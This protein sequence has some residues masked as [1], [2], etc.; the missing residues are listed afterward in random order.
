MEVMQ[1]F[2]TEVE[3][4][5]EVLHHFKEGVEEVVEEALLLRRRSANIP[6]VAANSG[7]NATVFP[8]AEEV[9]AVDLL[10]TTPKM[11]VASVSVDGD[12]KE[13][14]KTSEEIVYFDKN[15]GSGPEWS[16][17]NVKVEELGAKL[18]DVAINQVL[19]AVIHNKE[20]KLPTSTNPQLQEETDERVEVDDVLEETSDEEEIE[21]E[22][23]RAVERIHTHDDYSMYCPNC[24]SRITKVVL[25]RK[26]RQRRVQT[27]KETQRDDLFGCL[28][29]FSVFIPS[30]GNRLNPFRIFGAGKGPES[31]PLLQQEQQT[32]DVSMPTSVTAQDKGKGFDLFWIFG[33]RRP[34]EKLSGDLDSSSPKVTNE[35]RDQANDQGDGV[36]TFIPNAIPPVGM[37]ESKVATIGDG[38]MTFIPNAIPPVGMTESNVAT[39]G[40]GVKT[41]IPNALPAQG[42]V[43]NGNIVPIGIIDKTEIFVKKPKSEI[44]GDDVRIQVGDTPPVAPPI[45]PIT[46]VFLTDVRI[47]ETVIQSPSSRSLEIVKSIVYGGMMESIA[48]L[49]VVSSA[50]ASDATTLN[51]VALG[52]ANLVGGLVVLAHNLRDLRYGESSE[53]N[54]SRYKEQLGRKEHFFFHATLAV[55]S[56]LV[57]GLIPPVIYGF[58]FRESDDRDYKILAVAA[59]SLLCI[60]ILAIAKAYTRGEH[61]FVAYFKTILYYVTSAVLVSGIA[62]AVGNLVNK[63]LERLGWLNPATV[64]PQLF[65]QAKSFNP[66]SWASY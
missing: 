59:A 44:E 4:K 45:F 42:S 65:S 61:K 11:E 27:P 3:K 37:T 63:L 28:A 53:T 5:K 55:L 16:H 23:E 13:V 49:S 51:I 17:F 32:P 10:D 21:L 57:F 47:P 25:R 12:Q 7:G 2:R 9:A 19:S 38:V 8:A 18:K 52:L 1:Q 56:Y 6:T 22:F 34:H 40:D 26:I 64:E 48:S 20:V 36:M 41:F 31:S 43:L 60:V 50:A 54:E 58:T 29:C 46:D 14:E 35:P 24:S 33:K 30:A 62:Y 39:L 15:E 66:T